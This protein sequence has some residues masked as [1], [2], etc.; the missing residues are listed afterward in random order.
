[1][2]DTSNHLIEPARCA[3]DPGPARLLITGK[4]SIPADMVIGRPPGLS[5]ALKPPGVA[6]GQVVPRPRPRRVHR[7]RTVPPRLFTHPC[8]AADAR[9]AACRSGGGVIDIPTTASAVSAC[10]GP[11]SVS[12]P[13]HLAARADPART[14]QC[15][16]QRCARSRFSVGVWRWFSCSSR[17]CRRRGRTD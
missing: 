11:R 7:D 9:C 12:C 6:D 1:M 15:G 8:N 16:C 4:V 17:C 13:G 14:A 3:G 10:P 5:S 2:S